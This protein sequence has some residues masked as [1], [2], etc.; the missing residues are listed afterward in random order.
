MKL[1]D[2]RNRMKKKK[3]DFVRQD[4]TKKK[5]LA[6]NWRKPRGIDSKLRLQ[7]RGKGKLVKVGYKSPREVRGL[8]REGLK[9]VMICNVKDLELVKEGMIGVISSTVGIK[10]KIVIIKKA[11][12]KKIKLTNYTEE[13]I[14]KIEEKLKSK[15]TEQKEK[16][17]KKAAKEKAEKEKEAEKEEEKKPEDKNKSSVSQAE[18][19]KKELDK[20]LIKKGAV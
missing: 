12:E 10:K 15:K 9:E 17:I 20:A 16:E 19:K 7:L 8:N 13:F 3:P 18:L 11:T 5:R 6:K 1:I 2:L 4:V 14:K